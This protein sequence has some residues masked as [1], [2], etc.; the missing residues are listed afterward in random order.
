MVQFPHGQPRLACN[1]SDLL[2]SHDERMLQRFGWRGALIRVQ[3]QTAIQQ[4]H[5]G[6]ELLDVCIR[7][8]PRVA[9][10]PRPQVTGWFGEVEDA[11][12]VLRSKGSVVLSSH[13]LN[14]TGKWAERRDGVLTF[15]LILSVS[16]LRKLSKS[17]KCNPANCAFRSILWLNLPLHSMIERS[18]WLLVRPVNRILPVY[19]SKRVQPTDQVS[20]A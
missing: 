19:S 7:H 11:D 12:E 15:P 13:T 8:A 17:S 4:I 9:H 3:V 18:I 2:A 1:R 20:M 10:Q 14:A 6:T 5:K 16:T